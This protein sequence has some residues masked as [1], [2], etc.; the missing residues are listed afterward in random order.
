MDKQTLGITFTLAAIS[1]FVVSTS[2]MAEGSAPNPE[3]TSGDV[4]D[5]ARLRQQEYEINHLGLFQDAEASAEPAES[6]GRWTLAYQGKDMKPLEGS[7]FYERVGRSDLALAYQRKQ[8]LKV[9]LTATGGI[10]F[11]LGVLVEVVALAAASSGGCSSSTYFG[12]IGSRIEADAA[13]KVALIGLGLI[14][15]GTGLLVGGFVINPNPVSDAE[16]R[17]LVDEYNQR[18]KE[19]LGVSA[20]P[21]STP[22]QREKVRIALAPAISTSGGGLSLQVSF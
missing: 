9:G 1:M 6:R 17:R 3:E 12:C 2:A 21:E 7:A 14:A 16:A 4:S 19:R 18:L 10:F 20:K 8:G 15:G 5:L 13:G 22:E 11:G